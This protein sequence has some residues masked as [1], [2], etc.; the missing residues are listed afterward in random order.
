MGS[1]YSSGVLRFPLSRSGL[2]VEADEP[3]SRY[4]R[5]TRAAVTLVSLRDNEE[6]R[7]V[8]AGQLYRRT[9]RLSGP[10]Q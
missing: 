8:G 5:R 1:R 4:V 3:D 10:G 6:A 9:R 7:V 2:W